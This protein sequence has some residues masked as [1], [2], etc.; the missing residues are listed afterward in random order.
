MSRA[1]MAATTLSKPTRPEA[2]RQALIKAAPM[3]TLMLGCGRRPL[4]GAINHDARY[5]SSHVDVAWDLDRLPWPVPDRRFRRVIGL[6]VFEHMEA[7]MTVWLRECW[8]ILQDGGELVLRISHYANP[9]SYRDPTHR[10]AWHE[11]A[12]CFYDPRHTLY[13]EYGSMYADDWPT[14]EIVTL[15]LGN[16]DQRYP[17]RGDICAVLRKV[18][19]P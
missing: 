13:Q 4:V 16:A 9:V 17:D 12:L 2:I 18:G 5:H 8:R 7:E 10:W 14:F 11:E 3:T 19:R 6:D 1:D 15:E